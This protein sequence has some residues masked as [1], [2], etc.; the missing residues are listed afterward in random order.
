MLQN[1]RQVK[2]LEAV[3]IRRV[4]LCM[5]SQVLIYHV[6][7]GNFIISRMQKTEAGKLCNV[8]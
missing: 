6:M 8:S 4:K 1:N 7:E 2:V 3:E 5:H